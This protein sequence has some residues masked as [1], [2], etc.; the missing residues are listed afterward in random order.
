MTTVSSPIALKQA[1]P[2]EPGTEGDGKISNDNF[3][4]QGQRRWYGRCGV[5]HIEILLW[6]LNDFLLY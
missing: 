4:I 3:I 2:T 5:H 1:V 6:D